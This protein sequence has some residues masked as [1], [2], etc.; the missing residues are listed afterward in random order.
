MLLALALNCQSVL[1]HRKQKRAIGSHNKS[2]FCAYRFM[3]GY[4]VA[5]MSAVSLLTVGLTPYSPP[6]C[7]YCGG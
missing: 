3:V 4:R 5:L 6:P 7:L 2:L 1:V